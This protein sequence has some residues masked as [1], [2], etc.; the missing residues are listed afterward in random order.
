MDPQSGSAG[1]HERHLVPN[2]PYSLGHRDYE[3]PRERPLEEYAVGEIRNDL[4]DLN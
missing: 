4:K 1:Q 2:I 3:L